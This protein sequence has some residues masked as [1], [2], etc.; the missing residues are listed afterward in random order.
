MQ[1][2]MTRPSSA[3]MIDYWLGGVHNFEIDRQMGDQ[4]C[5]TLPVIPEWQ[6]TSR[7]ALG[8]AVRYMIEEMGLKTIVDFGA[9][10]PTCNN[11]HTLA[12]RISSDVKVLYSDIDPLTT[13]YGQQLLAG[14]SH[15]LYVQGDAQNPSSVLENPAS[16]EFL[17]GEHRVGIIFMGLGHIMPDDQLAQAARLLYDWA[18]PGSCWWLTNAPHQWETDPALHAVIEHY[19]R[20][21][22]PSWLRTSEQLLHLLRPWETHENS[23]TINFQW[24]LPDPDPNPPSIYSLETMVYR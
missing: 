16:R 20:A 2:D 12:E 1:I 17:A 10:L 23:V 14:N 8:R 24:G 3:R 11:T 9:G 4:V 22:M 7:I 15:T 19:R 6:R 13:A 5:Q 18:S 21:R